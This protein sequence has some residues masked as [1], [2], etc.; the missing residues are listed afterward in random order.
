MDYALCL[1]HHAHGVIPPLPPPGAGDQ[2]VTS[3]D[4]PQL[5][6]PFTAW[7]S[8]APPQHPFRPLGG[9]GP[10]LRD[11]HV[12]GGRQTAGHED[13]REHRSF[14]IDRTARLEDGRRLPMRTHANTALSI[15]TAPLGWRTAGGWP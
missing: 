5:H 4:T 2:H 10:H 6:P 14:N 1:G 11:D 15:S 12:V 9:P 7:G 8:R 3:N 13:T